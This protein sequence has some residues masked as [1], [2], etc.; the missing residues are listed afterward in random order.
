MPTRAP[1]LAPANRISPR[2]AYRT[3][4]RASSEIAVAIS[5]AWV[6][7]YPSSTARSRPRWR[8]AT[9]SRSEVMGTVICALSKRTPSVMGP[10]LFTVTRWL[11]PSAFKPLASHPSA[12]GSAVQVRE[13]LLQIERGGHAL[14]ADTELGHGKGDFWLN[15]HD[16][17]LRPAQPRHV[18]EIAQSAHGEGVHHVEGGHIDDDATGAIVTDLRHQRVAQVLEVGVG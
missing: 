5:V 11:T 3:M 15:P 4:L 16:H 18:C 2:V 12:L 1:S 14:Q 8:A 13:A 10:L 7:E 17:C 6:A 9:I